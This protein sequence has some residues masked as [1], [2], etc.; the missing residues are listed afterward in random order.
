MRSRLQEA[1]APTVSMPLFTQEK[2]VLA[3]LAD[4]SSRIPSSVSIHVSRLVIDLDSVRIKGT[5]DAFNNVNSIKKML[6]KSGRFADVN[7][8]SATKTKNKNVIRF[9]IRL[10]LREASS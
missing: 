8:V 7:I 3:I 5:T 2:R 4:I 10:L 1:Q 6:A 9:E